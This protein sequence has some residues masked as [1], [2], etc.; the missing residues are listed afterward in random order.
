MSFILKVDSVSKSF[1]KIQAL[2]GVSLQVE[3]GEIY[4]LIGPDGAGKSTLMKII[5]GIL[6]FHEG[7]VEV[8]GYDVRK[9][10]EKVKAVISFM[11]QGIGQNLYQ[12]LSVE[13]N[14]DFFVKLKGLEP[15]NISEHKERLLEITGLKPFRNRLAK[16]LSG[17]MQQKLGI[18]CSLITRPKLLILDEPTTGVDPVSRREI[19]DIIYE[20]AAQGVTVLF[21]TSYMDEAERAHRFS[22][23][24]E[25]KVIAQV[26]TD[27]L[28]ASGK[29]V[30]ELFK[31]LVPSERFEVSLP[32]E[33]E[34]LSHPIGVDR[35]VKKFGS[36]VAVDNVAFSIEPGEI[37]GLLGPNGAGKTTTIKIMVGL[38]KP[39]SGT[40]KMVS[41]KQLGYM[42]QK[43][44]LYKDLTVEENI[45][46]YG[47]VYGLGE[48]ELSERKR[49][50]LEIARLEEFRDKLVNEL[51]L[52][53]RQRLALGCSFIHVPQVLFL[54][55][56][57]SGVDPIT[58]E[59]FWEII[60]VLS[61][62][63][64]TVVVTT[65]HLLELTTV[66][67]WP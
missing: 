49:W 34:R 7:K 52:G 45:E 28:V 25:G 61:E 60:R 8:C 55:E 19:W 50:I 53:H 67:D 5:S 32:F 21:S 57:T 23:M 27:E 41:K 1:K 62:A 31:S 54:D 13:E 36:F 22:L 14:I 65:H 63:G 48:R 6:S 64:V 20:F 38:L 43:F 9:Y 58:R 15:S 29:S 59:A 17:G 33:I 10:P 66:T 3:E 35:L 56:P 44:S 4:G 39:T 40:I 30:D 11:P 47:A 18:C 26:E 16:H 24:H 12:D 2:K 46:Y 37:F 42:S 51:P